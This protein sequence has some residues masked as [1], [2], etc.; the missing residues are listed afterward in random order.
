MAG[1]YPIVSREDWGQ[2]DLTV[3]TGAGWD[4]ATPVTNLLIPRP[5]L[6]CLSTGTGV[7]V[8]L[9]FSAPQNIGLIH[10]QRLDVDANATI[11]VTAGTYNSGIVPAWPFDSNGPYRPREWI[12]LG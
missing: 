3:I 4:A 7:N 2:D 12:G 8:T 11:Q 9:N 5:Q 6:G 1:R 10:V